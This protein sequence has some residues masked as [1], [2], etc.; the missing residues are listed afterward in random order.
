MRPSAHCSETN[1]RAGV[2]TKFGTIEDRECQRKGIHMRQAIRAIAIG[3]TLSMLLWG[4]A[5][6]K[7]QSNAATPTGTVVEKT[8]AGIPQI[9]QLTGSGKNQFTQSDSTTSM[10]TACG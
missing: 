7:A 3:I 1:L 5:A 10:L 9:E 4:G 2:K 6:S 8:G